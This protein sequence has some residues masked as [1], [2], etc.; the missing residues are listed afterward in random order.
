MK[1][2]PKKIALVTGACGFVGSHMVDLL[3]AKGYKVRA[4]DLETADSK[5]L[6][7]SKNVE[8]VPADVTKKEELP[9]LFEGVGKVFHTAAILK[10]RVPWELL[11][12]VNVMGTKNICEVALDSGIE[13][14]IVWSSE[15][16]YGKTGKS[17]A[18]ETKFFSPLGKYE[19]SKALQDRLA[20]DFY[21]KKGLPVTIIRP[22]AIY[23]PRSKSGVSPLIFLMSDVQFFA[24]PGKK[25]V[26]GAL[27]HVQ[28]IV[29][30]A[31]FLSGKKKTIGQMYNVN[32]DKSSVYTKKELLLYASKLLNKKLYT[33]SIPMFLIYFFAEMLELLGEVIKRD[34]NIEKGFVK[35]LADDY[36][37]D[38]SKIK[39]LGYKF[40][41]PDT[42]AGFK[43]TIDWFEKEGWITIRNSK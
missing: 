41:Y 4:T 18:D 1:S 40:I 12:N 38:N 23:G 17:A 7:K 24:I 37:M 16:V 34:S 20:M 26:K 10:F 2:N 9:P 21:K 27:V 32:D 28:D 14:M 3:V 22:A 30:A 5:Y 43:D 11:Y 13:H 33:F 39:K 31:Y 8:F 42:K 6:N 36:V 29:N 15:T 25:D 35:Y 19:K